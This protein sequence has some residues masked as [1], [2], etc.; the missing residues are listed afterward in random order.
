V[1]FLEDMSYC[2]AKLSQLEQAIE[3]ISKAFT[4]LEAYEAVYLAFITMLKT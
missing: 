1:K 2:H 3:K 4:I